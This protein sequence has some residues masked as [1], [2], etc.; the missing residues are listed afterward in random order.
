MKHKIVAVHDKALDAYLRPFTA[1]TTGVAIRHFQDE[2]ANKESP[3]HTHPEDYTL[4]LL[5]DYEEDTGI[6]TPQPG[7]PLAIAAAATIKQH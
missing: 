3:M 7:G 2:I 4:H 5:G 6:I 1:P